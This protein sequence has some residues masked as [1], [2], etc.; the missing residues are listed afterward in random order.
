MSHTTNLYELK[1][2]NTNTSDFN[3]IK[4]HIS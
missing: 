2:Y 4:L 1:K 3:H